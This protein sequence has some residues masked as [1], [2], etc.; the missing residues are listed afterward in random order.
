M[1]KKIGE[2]L[3]EA[4][5]KKGLELE[6]IAE[7]TKIQLRYLKALENG[8]FELMPGKTYL[9]GFL[10]NFAL[11][12]GLDKNK[13]MEMYEEKENDKIELEEFDEELVED[14]KKNSMTKNTII[15]FLILLFFYIAV[16]ALKLIPNDSDAVK[17]QKIESKL[18]K[19]KEK[20]IKKKKVEER[21]E[22]EIKKIEFKKIT[23]KS[24]NKVWI[25]VRDGGKKDFVGYLEKGKEVEIKSK[26]KILIKASQANK[27]EI[28]YNGENLGELGSSEKYWKEF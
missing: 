14:L 11:V 12:V 6:D 9:K 2:T 8:D 5:E 7:E 15:A 22:L 17:N 26:N 18:E 21:K 19:K 3:K 23:I 24:R 4:R 20:K 1:N 25:E 27:I 28:I 16:N 10:K 13:I